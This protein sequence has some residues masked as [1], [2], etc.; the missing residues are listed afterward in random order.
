MF[1]KIV[2]K[3]IKTNRCKGLKMLINNKEDGFLSRQ[4]KPKKSSIN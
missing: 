2:E 3:T 4:Y 1:E